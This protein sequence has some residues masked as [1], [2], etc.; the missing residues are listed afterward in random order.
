MLQG[1]LTPVPCLA[2]ISFLGSRKEQTFFQPTQCL[3]GFSRACACAL[4]YPVFCLD[5]LSLYYSAIPTGSWTSLDGSQIGVGVAIFDHMGVAI[6]CV[7]MMVNLH[8]TSLLYNI[9]CSFQRLLQRILVHK[10]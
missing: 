10:L 3:C 8:I 9:V 2:S 7:G 1:G 4:P 6:L 5:S